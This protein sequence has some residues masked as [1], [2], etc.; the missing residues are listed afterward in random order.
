MS[1]YAAILVLPGIIYFHHKWLLILLIKSTAYWKHSQIHW[2]SLYA[3]DFDKCFGD[4]KVVKHSEIH[5]KFVMR[6]NEDVKSF[7]Q[8][9][10]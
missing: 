7:S 9:K 2:Y 6:S 8:H 4:V 3:L 5:G 10:V 1:T